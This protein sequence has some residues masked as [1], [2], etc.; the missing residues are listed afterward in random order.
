MEPS[1]CPIV[2][3]ILTVGIDHLA[4]AQPPLLVGELSAEDGRGRIT[5]DRSS[6]IFLSVDDPTPSAVEDAFDRVLGRDALASPGRWEG[7]R[8]SLSAAGIEASEWYLAAT[9]RQT[10]L[11][12][13]L[14]EQLPAI[15]LAA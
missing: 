8:T 6:R 5:A 15:P 13:A 7:L 10:V 2:R 12:P 11:D 3:V 14:L 4:A 1:P 9:P